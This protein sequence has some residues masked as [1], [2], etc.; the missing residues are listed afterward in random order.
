MAAIPRMRKASTALFSGWTAMAVAR[1]GGSRY[2][3]FTT[4]R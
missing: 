3:R 4:I 1:E 2:I